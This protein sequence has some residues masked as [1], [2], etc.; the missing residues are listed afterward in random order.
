M[1]KSFALLCFM[2]VGALSTC[3]FGQSPSASE[4]SLWDHNGSVVYLI[5]KGSSREFY[6]KEPRGGMV[7]AGAR[8]GSLLFRGETRGGQYFGTAFIFNRRCGQFPY[9]VKGPILDN[10]DRV[11]LKG[12]APEVGANCRIEGY[13]AD[14][15]QFTLL[16]S[17]EPDTPAQIVL[18]N[19]ST[20][21]AGGMSSRTVARLKSDGGTYVVPVQING[22]IT[23]DFII[24]SGASDVS[25]PAD[26]V[27]TL[28]RTGTIRD[29][30]FI[31]KQTYILADGSK[32]PSA[33]FMIRSLKVGNTVIENVKGDIAPAQASLL[34]GQSFLQHF[35]SWSINNATHELVLETGK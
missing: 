32:A 14:T 21:N 18:P 35:K 30:D 23:L 8:P 1:S 22:A 6:Y 34:L 25:V 31:G 12:N 16:K 11:L 2:M 29:S 3:A 4:P 28:I 7:E 33:V 13:V 19:T 5:A 10:Y 20:S 17:E 15:L 9:D 26:V 24:D 27:S